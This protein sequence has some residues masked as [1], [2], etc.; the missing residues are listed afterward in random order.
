MARGRSER[1]L[2]NRGAGR[3]RATARVTSVLYGSSLGWRLV[4]GFWAAFIAVTFVVGGAMHAPGM[5]LLLRL[6]IALAMLVKGRMGSSSF[7]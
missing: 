4:V 6:I 1:K 2:A 5:A 7:R 3:R